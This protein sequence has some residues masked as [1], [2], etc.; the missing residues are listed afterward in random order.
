M[1]PSVDTG[2]RVLHSEIPNRRFGKHTWPRERGF[3][4]LDGMSPTRSLRQFLER[5]GAD[6]C[7]VAPVERF[8]DAPAGFHPRDLYEGCR[9]VIVF[10]K[11]LPRATLRVSP[12]LLYIHA[13]SE[14]L[15]ELDRLAFLVSRE[16]EQAGGEA[17]AVPADEPYEF[18]DAERLTAR[19]LLSLKHAGVLAGLGEIGKNTL[20]IHPRFGNRL[21]LGCVLTN[22]EL[23]PDA[24]QP[25]QLCP[26]T[27]RICITRCPQRALDGHT[28]V[29]ARCRQLVYGKNAKGFSIC[30]CNACRRLCPQA[31]K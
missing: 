18:W 25:P 21:M 13:M 12:R 20:L 28:L 15:A 9:A 22:V 26:P 5:H 24:V 31:R 3:A 6:V 23:E 10:G 30:N 11:A 27:C 4:I 1:R 8:A 29:Q 7:G 17:V 14:C 19:G 2:R 16:L